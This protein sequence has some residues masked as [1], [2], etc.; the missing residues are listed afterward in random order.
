M[1]PIDLGRPGTATSGRRHAAAGH[2]NEMEP[3]GQRGGDEK[4]RWGV[5]INRRSLS[6]AEETVGIGRRSIPDW[7]V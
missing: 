6:I 4:E 1:D 5:R 7:L 3:V 2:L